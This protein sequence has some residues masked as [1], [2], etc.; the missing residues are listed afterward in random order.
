MRNLSIFIFLAALLTIST[1]KGQ[2]LPKT[3]ELGVLIGR[4]YYMGEINPNHHIGYNTG[5][6]VYGI[7]YRFN[8]NRRYSLKATLSQVELHADDKDNKLLFNQARNARFKNNLTDIAANIEFNFLPYVIGSK[9]YFFSPYL[10]VGFNVFVSR[11]ETYI[12][13][14]QLSGESVKK[15]TAMA[16]SFG[17]GIKLNL[18]RKASISFEWGFRKT[19][20][21]YIDG[22]RN[23]INDVIELGK[24]YDNDWYVC[25]NLM[26]TYRITK[27]SACPA[28]NNF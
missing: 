20:Y 23:R 6:L 13:D 19:G 16:Y 9:Q 5:G 2:K 25:S 21:D 3:A 24:K 17:P 1:A 12:N 22:L 28:Y 11:P 8:L 26:L 14:I 15:K 7:L 27:P 10:F 18:G 4:S